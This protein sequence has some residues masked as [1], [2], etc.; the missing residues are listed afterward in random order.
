LRLEK[1]AGAIYRL[2]ALFFDF[3]SQV[4]Q[5]GVLPVVRG[6]FDHHWQV[7][8]GNYFDL[9]L[10]NEHCGNISRCSAEHVRKNDDAATFRNIL[11]GPR[12]L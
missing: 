2:F 4:V 7:N 11:D 5:G 8:T 10:F 1:R 3:T 12:D 9:V 6:Q